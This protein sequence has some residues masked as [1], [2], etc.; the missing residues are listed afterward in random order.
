M[1]RVSNLSPVKVLRLYFLLEEPI[2]KAEPTPLPLDLQRQTIE[3]SFWSENEK[4]L[5]RQHQAHLLYETPIDGD[6]IETFLRAYRA[7]AETPHAIGIANPISH[8]AHHIRWAQRIFA[9]GLESTARETPPL[10]LWTG[11]IPVEVEVSLADLLQERTTALWLRTA[12]YELFGLPNLAHP[13]ADVR[14]TGWVHSLFELLFDWMYFDGRPLEVG[15]AIEVPE[16]GRYLIEDFMPSVLA[17]I[18][19]KVSAEHA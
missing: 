12:G 15:D 10:H 9:D 4:A 13:I 6:P 2:P 17:L 11:L 16:R 14:E 5:L 1:P 18:E 7:A 19:W 3:T 8:T